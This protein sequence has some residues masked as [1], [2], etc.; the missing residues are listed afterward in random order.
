MD[1]LK[2]YSV[3]QLKNIVA[4][5][6]A[7]EKANVIKGYGAM[8]K[9][10]LVKAISDQIKQEHL[11]KILDALQLTSIAVG[12]T[13]KIKV[14]RQ[15][16]KMETKLVEEMLMMMEEGGSKVA[17]KI[18]KSGMVDE[19]TAKQEE[20][21]VEDFMKMMESQGSKMTEKVKK[22][23]G[24]KPRTGSKK[25]QMADVFEE[26]DVRETILTY[27]RLY[28]AL[29]SIDAQDTTISKKTQSNIDVVKG[30]IAEIQR[31]LTQIGEKYKVEGIDE[32]KMLSEA[33]DDFMEY[34]TFQIADV[35]DE[36]GFDFNYD[37]EDGISVKTEDMSDTNEFKKIMKSKD[38][39]KY[40]VETYKKYEPAVGIDIA[41]LIRKIMSID[42]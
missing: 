7:S 5:H 23:I 37:E 41:T 24:V 28:D 16:N 32:D 38:I 30:F 6:N 40:I 25:K 21:I 4:T 22:N 8:K 36:F 9:P 19:M 20:K 1:A 42:K 33:M 29:T 2:S 10:E 15:P 11:M 18:R 27:M 35:F 17:E 34:Q 26:N 39:P 31:Y 3:K 14:K 13:M 12:E